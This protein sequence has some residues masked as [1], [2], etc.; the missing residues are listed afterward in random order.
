MSSE[1][2]DSLRFTRAVVGHLDEGCRVRLALLAQDRGAFGRGARSTIVRR[3]CVRAC[4]GS[5]R[6]VDPERDVHVAD[7]KHVCPL[8]PV[9]GTFHRDAKHAVDEGVLA[10]TD[11]PVASANPSGSTKRPSSRNGTIVTRSIEAHSTSSVVRRCEHRFVSQRRDELRP[12]RETEFLGD[13]VLRI[14]ELRASHPRECGRIAG[15]CGREQFLGLAA[16]LF[17]VE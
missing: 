10:V 8:T 12:T 7:S 9:P 15:M 4:R 6:A 3:A 1:Y 14:R 16:G 5:A 2:C 13:G 11:A 17:E